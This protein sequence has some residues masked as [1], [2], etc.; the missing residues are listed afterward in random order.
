MSLQNTN[1]V[2]LIR[3]A[4]FGYNEE[5]A[6]SNSF[7][8]K[9]IQSREEVLQKAREEFNHV[10]ATLSANGIDVNI[11]DDTEVPVKPDAVFPNNWISFG[12]D[13]KVVLYPMHTPNRRQERRLDIIEQLGEKFLF[14]DIID[15][16]PNEKENRIVEGTGSII[17][18]HENK[19]AYACLSPRTNKNLFEEI[20][21]RLQYKPVAFVALNESGQEIYHT[22]VM[23]CIGR[24]FAV[25]CME[26]IT[27]NDERKMVA[28]QFALSGHEIIDISF[29]Q[30]N[31]FAGNMLELATASGKFITVLSQSAYDVLSHLQKETIEKLSRLLPLSIP[32]IETVGGGSVRCMIAEIFCP[33]K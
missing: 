7:Q 6:V 24:K 21:K 26:S 14:N 20:C 17:F 32:T 33:K 19:V 4:F 10:A 13:S 1:S 12:S 25:V 18:D 28:D 22:N 3:P 23:M 9:P 30:M 29:S 5:T 16:T 8:N 27:D 31:H 2:L 11:I 15:Y